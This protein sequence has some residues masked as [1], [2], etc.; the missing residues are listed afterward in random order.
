MAHSCN[1]RARRGQGRLTSPLSAPA[2]LAARPSEKGLRPRPAV[3]DKAEGGLRLAQASVEA[4]DRG[5]GGVD[6]GDGGVRLREAAPGGRPRSGA[7][8]A[9]PDGR[10][11]AAGQAAAVR[12]AGPGGER[13]RRAAVDGAAGGVG[14]GG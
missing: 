4:G 6:G 1:T 3:L 11:G 9:R 10:G 13:R 2:R 8:A 12:R 14:E 7:V 5:G